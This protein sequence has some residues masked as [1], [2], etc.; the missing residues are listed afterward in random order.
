MT[1]DGFF[2]PGGGPVKPWAV[3]ARLRGGI[4]RKRL[5]PAAGFASGI[6]RNGETGILPAADPV[7]GSRETEA[8]SRSAQLGDGQRTGRYS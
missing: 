5:K 2:T 6:R 1:R 4:R 7:A 8:R 3:Q